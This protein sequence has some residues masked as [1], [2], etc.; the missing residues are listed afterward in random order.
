MN[1]LT[2]I[3]RWMYINQDGLKILC[4]RSPSCDAT[5]RSKRWLMRFP[6]GDYSIPRERLTWEA[7]SCS[8]TTDQLQFQF[9]GK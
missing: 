8:E 4:R 7:E 5:S 1:W 9:E 2:K 6:E 3:A